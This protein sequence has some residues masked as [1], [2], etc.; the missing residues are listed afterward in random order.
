MPFLLH[1]V[2]PYFLSCQFYK[3]FEANPS[4]IGCIVVY[5]FLCMLIDFILCF[6]SGLL[7]IYL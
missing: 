2:P 3:P 4:I 5:V 7:A 1:L 6:M